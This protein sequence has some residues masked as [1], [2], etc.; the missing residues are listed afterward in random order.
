MR[1]VQRMAARRISDL[2]REYWFELLIGALG[3]AAILELITGRDSPGAP[4]TSLWFAVPAVAVLVGSLF[5]RKLFPF[6]APAAYWLLATALS[7]ACSSRS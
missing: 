3:V 6:G 5:A 7:T 4:G 1:Y 2:T